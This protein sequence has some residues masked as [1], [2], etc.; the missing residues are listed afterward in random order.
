MIVP[1]RVEEVIEVLDHDIGAVE[2]DGLAHLLRGLASLLGLDRVLHHPK[3]L[4]VVFWDDYKTTWIEVKS[5][6]L[7]ARRLVDGAPF[8]CRAGWLGRSLLLRLT[9]HRITL[10]IVGKLGVGRAA[11]MT[12][13]LVLLCLLVEEFLLL[14]RGIGPRLTLVS[15]FNVRDTGNEALLEVGQLGPT[16]LVND[17]RALNR[18][19][20]LCLVHSAPINHEQCILLPL[21]LVPFKSL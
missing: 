19:D 7:S 12:E 21:C 16:L 18:E 8:N 13:A 5:T 14:D 9:L 6:L 20:K 1:C 3:R 4:G 10:G 2:V 15:L 11:R 17:S